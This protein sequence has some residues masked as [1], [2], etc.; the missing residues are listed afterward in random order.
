MCASGHEAL[1]SLVKYRPTLIL[2]DLLMPG[3]DGA[4]FRGAQRR[5]QDHELAKVP[6]VVISGAGNARELAR[7]LGA[8][9]VFEKSVDPDQI[10]A[11]VQA[12]VR[13]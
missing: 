11:A 5:L 3:M 8:A 9:G 2:L 1:D 4:Q 10:L 13:K 6:I 7:T 12:R